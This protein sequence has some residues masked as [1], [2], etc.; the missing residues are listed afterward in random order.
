ME[1]FN[2]DLKQFLQSSLCIL[3]LLKL[4]CTVVKNI[5]RNFQ[6]SFKKSERVNEVELEAAS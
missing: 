6:F 5:F 1:I 3:K 2:R 4:G